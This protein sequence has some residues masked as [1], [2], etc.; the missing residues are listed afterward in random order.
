MKFTKKRDK[1][2]YKIDVSQTRES[3]RHFQEAD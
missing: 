2:Q 3:S 1:N